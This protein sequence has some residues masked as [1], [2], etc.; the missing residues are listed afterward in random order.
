MTGDQFK[1]WRESLGFTQTDAAEAI[2]KSLQT[3]WRY[4]NG[5]AI[6]KTTELACKWV[7]WESQT[8]GRAQKTQPLHTLFIP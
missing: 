5:A 7:S 6:P 2:G 8:T 1:A 4:E 3:V